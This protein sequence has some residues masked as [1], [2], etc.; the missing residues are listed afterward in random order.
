MLE[1]GGTNSELVGQ[2]D[3]CSGAQQ[4]EN[5]VVVDRVPDAE[6]DFTRHVGRYGFFSTVPVADSVADKTLLLKTVGRKIAKLIH[7]LF[8]HEARLHEG[9]FQQ[10]ISTPLI[11]VDFACANSLYET[12]EMLK[13]VPVVS[14]KR[15]R[16][17]SSQGPCVDF[18]AQATE[19]DKPLFKDISHGTG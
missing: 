4:L 19:E 16:E 14:S 11:V 18:I 2:I 1:S 17:D 15:S 6:H 9:R 8:S 12:Q 13:D 3:S 5:G 7:Q 10:R